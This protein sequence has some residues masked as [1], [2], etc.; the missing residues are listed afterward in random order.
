[1]ERVLQFPLFALA[2]FYV[3]SPTFVRSALEVALAA[4]YRCL[5]LRRQ[6]IRENIARAQAARPDWTPPTEWSI[7]RH[8]A[9]LTWEIC[10][11]FGPMKRYCEKYSVVEGIEHWEKAKS[12][13]KGVICLGSHIGNWEVMGGACSPLGVNMMLV[14]K[15]LKPPFIFNGIIEGRKKIGVLA[16]YEP[17]TLKD[18]LKHLKAGGTIGMVIDQYAGPPVGIRVPFFGIPVGTQS[19]VAFLAKRTGAPVVPAYSFW[20]EK[21]RKRVVRIEPILEWESSD[22]AEYEIAVNTARMSSLIENQVFDHPSEWLWS[23]RRFKGDLSPLRVGEWTEG[24]ARK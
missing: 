9:R 3:Y 24:R 19:A 11:L 6:V 23:H 14:T 16:T 10:L 5:K 2:S 13:G 12:L 21:R 1:M 8:L 17:R 7:Y 18:V 15:Q 20:D 4:V 22:D